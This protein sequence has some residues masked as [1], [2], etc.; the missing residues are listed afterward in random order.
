MPAPA[1]LPP[2]ASAR[3]AMLAEML[4]RSSPK[5]EADNRSESG[6]REASRGEP[7]AQRKGT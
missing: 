6:R 5:P 7:V 1:S 3:L 4:E 2:D